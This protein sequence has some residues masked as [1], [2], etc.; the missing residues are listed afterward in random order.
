MQYLKSSYQLIKGNKDQIWKSKLESYKKKKNL[1]STTDPF[2]LTKFP[3]ENSVTWNMSK[4]SYQKSAL[5]NFH[6]D[7]LTSFQGSH[8]INDFN[9]I[10]SVWYPIHFVCKFTNPDSTPFSGQQSE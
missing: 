3:G 9:L 8:K 5:L 1:G 7:Q 6:T 4:F 2:Y 10:T